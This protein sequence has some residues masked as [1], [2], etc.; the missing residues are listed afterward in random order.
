MALLATAVGAQAAET[1][2]RV[3]VAVGEVSAVRGG[4]EIPLQT[5]S[6]IEAGDRVRTGAA[7]NAQ[8]RLTDE[9]IVALRP[10]TEFVFTEYRYAGKDD[11][12]ERAFFR[13]LKGGLRTITGFVG[14]HNHQNYGIETATAT[15]GIRGTHYVLM[16][17]EQNCLNADGSRAPDGL[18]GNATGFSFGTNRVS[19]TN[20]TGETV[21]GVN[22]PFHVPDINTEPRRL[23]APPDFL[24]DRL[25]GRDRNQAKGPGKEGVQEATGGTSDGRAAAILPPPES[26]PDVAT[27]QRD[28]TGQLAVLGTPLPSVGNGGVTYFVDVSSSFSEALVNASL[29][30]DAQGQ[31]TAISGGQTTATRGSG[32]A[33]DVG[34]NSAAGNLHWGMWPVASVN[35]SPATYLHYIV[36]DAASLPGT[37]VFTYSPVGGTLPTN[38]AGVTGAFLGGTVTVD[39]TPGTLQLNNWAVA[40]NGANYTQSGGGAATFGRSPAFSDQVTWSCAGSSC[41]TTTGG[42]INGNFSGS[43]TGAGATGLGIVYG[44]PDTGNNGQIVGAQGFKR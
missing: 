28:S 20:K 31:L 11:G 23:I 27:Q 36:G 9:S 22:Q 12:S 39:F 1:I 37:G 25:P 19:A 41:G 7:S 5:T 40:F 35:G 21:F 33:K 18:Y 14:R 17:C 4:R 30:A 8:I 6:S 13:L 43:F 16:L 26:L 42:T 34:S 44:V 3:L 10:E 32:G 2:G 24:A 29:T 38:A 15:I